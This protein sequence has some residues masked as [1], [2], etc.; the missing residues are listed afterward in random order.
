MEEQNSNQP[1]VKQETTQTSSSN[2]E[3]TMSEE[4]RKIAHNEANK[5]TFCSPK[6]STSQ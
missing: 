6:Q 3:K 4:E 5:K 2:D 1:E